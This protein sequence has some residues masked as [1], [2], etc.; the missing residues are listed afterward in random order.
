VAD[1]RERRRL[2]L[3]RPLI[4]AG[5]LAYRAGAYVEMAR[6]RAGTSFKEPTLV[7]DRAKL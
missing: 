3:A 2:L 5:S 6:G 7:V 1:P 4:V